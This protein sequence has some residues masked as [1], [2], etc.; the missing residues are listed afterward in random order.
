VEKKSFW[1]GKETELVDRDGKVVKKV[2]KDLTPLDAFLE[3][4]IA[5][6]VK[7]NSG[8]YWNRENSRLRL[9]VEKELEG[10]GDSPEK[11]V[12]GI[13]GVYGRVKEEMRTEFIK[14]QLKK[15]PKTREQL[16]EIA[17]SFREK[18]LALGEFVQSAIRQ[19]GELAGLTG[20]WEKDSSSVFKYLGNWVDAVVPGQ[21]NRELL[22]RMS[23]LVERKGSNY[24]KKAKSN[25]ELVEWLIDFVFGIEEIKAEEEKRKKIIA[26]QQ[27]QRQNPVPARAIASQPKPRQPIRKARL[28]VKR[29][30]TR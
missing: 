27:R 5:E 28:A 9:G 21:N 8:L 15:E 29:P 17:D 4:A 10:Y 16:L 25:K 30:I 3:E 1:N 11:A 23:F 7:E 13:K 6:K 26:S 22:E 19:D 12:E 14:N 24:A 18:G 20:E 2:G